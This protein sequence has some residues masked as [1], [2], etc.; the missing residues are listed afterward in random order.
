MIVSVIRVA[1]H[2]Q[3][4]TCLHAMGVLRQKSHRE[5]NKCNKRHSSLKRQRTK[6]TL[7]FHKESI[8]CH[9]SVNNSLGIYKQQ[10]ISRQ[11]IDCKSPS[12]TAA[13]LSRGCQITAACD[14]VTQPALREASIAHAFLWL[15]GTC[16]FV[17][18]FP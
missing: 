16:T 5:G 6:S 17:S 14:A 7:E 3:H 12:R 2:H 8:R 9:Q 13:Q 1:A 15:V 10:K 11:K 4:H 18:R